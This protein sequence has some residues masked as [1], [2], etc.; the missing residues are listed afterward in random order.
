M[1]GLNVVIIVIVVVLAAVGGYAYKQHRYEQAKQQARDKLVKQFQDEWSTLQKE[2]SDDI[3]LGNMTVNYPDFSMDASIRDIPDG[4]IL[5]TTQT[6][7]L[8]SAAKAG[9]C[10][11]AFTYDEPKNEAS[12]LSYIVAKEDRLSFTLVYRTASGYQLY[13]KRL[14]LTDC[15]RFDEFYEAYT[16]Q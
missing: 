12:R 9:L 11:G 10:D 15:P 1:R 14:Y 5:N 3:M 7:M 13:K 2:Q 4:Q 16:K 8:D 6:Q